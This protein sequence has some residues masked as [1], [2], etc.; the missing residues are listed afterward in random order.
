VCRLA[1]RSEAAKRQ[2]VLAGPGQATAASSENRSGPEPTRARRCRCAPQVS[3]RRAS[4]RC[5]GPPH[6]GQSCQDCPDRILPLE[7]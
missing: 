4:A 2:A 3:R 1:E 6:Q 7:G 5:S